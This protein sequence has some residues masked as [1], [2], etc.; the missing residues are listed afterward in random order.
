[1]YESVERNPKRTGKNAVPQLRQDQ[2]RSV[3]ERIGGPIQSYSATVITNSST[4]NWNSVQVFVFF[5]VLS[6]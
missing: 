6:M 3:L 4:Y 2:W 1:M 5:Q